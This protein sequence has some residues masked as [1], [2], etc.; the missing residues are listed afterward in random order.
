M[1]TTSQGLTVWDLPT[2][3]FDHTQMSGN[4]DLINSLLGSPSKSV[5]TLSTIPTSSNFAGRTV[6]LSSTDGGFQPWTLIRY[7]G[8]TWRPVNQIE[9]QPAVPTL[10]LFAGR[11]VILSVANGGFPAWAI[12]RYD[13]SAWQIVGGWQTVNTGANPSNISGLSSSGDVYLSNS[14][15]GLVLTDRGNG[16]TY[17]LYFQ[18]GNLSFEAV[19]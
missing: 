12:I 15:R 11:V 10:G 6:M 3:Q 14:A 4:W 16:L 13:G 5:E 17:R 7:D 2:D 8:S 1:R 9:I 19:A 18:N